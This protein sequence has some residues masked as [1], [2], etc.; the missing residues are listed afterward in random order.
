ME[1]HTLLRPGGPP[2]DYNLE[3][4]TTPAGTRTSLGPGRQVL[5]HIHYLGREQ[6]RRKELPWIEF[7]VR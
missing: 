7:P 5:P 6:Y 3:V 1:M 2:M 4:V